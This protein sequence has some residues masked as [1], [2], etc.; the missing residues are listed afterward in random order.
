MDWHRWCTLEQHLA[1][2][3]SVSQPVYVQT[4][5]PFHQYNIT[6]HPSTLHHCIGVPLYITDIIAH[7]HML[8]TVLSN[9]TLIL[10][11][12]R[13][14]F[15]SHYTC[16]CRNNYPDKLGQQWVHCGHRQLPWFIPKFGY[17]VYFLLSIQPHQP[18]CAP[19][20]SRTLLAQSNPVPKAASV[21]SKA[22]SP[23]HFTA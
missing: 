9:Q 13:N 16:T 3:W 7:K 23:L 1:P 17:V 15:V 5:I 11:V 6:Q 21:L 20:I 22:R 2:K 18:T 8:T 10:T 4:Q 12:I 14:S 19:A